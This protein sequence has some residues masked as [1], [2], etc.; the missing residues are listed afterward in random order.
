M[1]QL[2]M[3]LRILMRAEITLF[4]ADAQ[5]R[6]NVLLLSGLSIACIVVALAFVNVGIFFA[7]T[8]S[9]IDSRAAFILA[10]GNLV[11]AAVPYLI[12]KLIKPGSEEQLVRDIRE[13]ALEELSKD[14]EG[15]TQEFASI[16]STLQQMK[17]GVSSF[18][19]GVT[20]LAPLIGIA[21]DM[22]KKK[23]AD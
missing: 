13:M 3:K 11:V 22:L 23:K 20:A 1:N 15:V 4:K 18:G 5:R 8:N 17:S 2:V 7:L 12:G 21:V 6:A 16:G 19:G 10:A 9:A 14:V